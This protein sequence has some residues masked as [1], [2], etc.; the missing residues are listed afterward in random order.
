LTSSNS[1][2]GFADLTPNGAAVRSASDAPARRD[3]RLRRHTAGVEVLAAQS[4]FSTSTTG[5]PRVAAAAAIDNPAAPA[6]MTQ[7]SE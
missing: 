4:A 5:T 7:R 2:V 3:H 6:P 1:T